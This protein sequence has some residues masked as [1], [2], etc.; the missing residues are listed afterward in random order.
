MSF[1]GFFRPQTA[2]EAVA[3]HQRLGSGAVYVAGTTDVLVANRESDRFAGKAAIDLTGVEELCHI[4]EEAYCLRIGAMCT[5]AQIAENPLVR[6][7]AAVLAEACGQ[8]GSPQIRNRGT[9]GGNLANASP[10]ADSFGPLA[11]LRARIVLQSGEVMR[12]LPISEFITGPGKSA[13]RC[14]ELV[15]E[16][17]VEK[18]GDEY[19]QRFYKLG[20]RQALAIS[21]LTVSVAGKQNEKGLVEDLRVS[22]G[23][24]FPRPMMFDEVNRMAEGQAP[25]VE[26][27]RRVA[28]RMAGKLPEIAGV[29]AST[30]YKQPVSGYLVERLLCELYEVNPDG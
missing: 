8:V 4:T 7:Y 3:L 22:L 14:G 24:A 11:L 18:L 1:S 20:R 13:L 29:R 19:R 5:H 25:S 6:R 16:V 21:R 17:V 23:A 15:R 10:A 27:F 30:M 28:E 12:T 2:A 9:L 26:L